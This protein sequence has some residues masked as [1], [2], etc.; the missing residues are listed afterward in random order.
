[1]DNN[2]KIALAYIRD[3]HLTIFPVKDI[4]HAVRLADAISDSDP[5]N[6]TIGFSFLDVCEYLDGDIGECWESEEGE[7]FEEY[8]RDHRGTKN[9]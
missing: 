6:D 8:W 5:L 7:N 9:L 4:D 1:M 2:A 3:G